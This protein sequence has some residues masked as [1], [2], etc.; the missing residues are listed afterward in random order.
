MNVKEQIKRE[1]R[2]DFKLSVS[3][4]RLVFWETIDYNFETVL[5]KSQ[6]KELID[7]LTELRDQ[8]G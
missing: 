8:M 6:V 4:D 5:T 2:V 1:L 3:R 7:T